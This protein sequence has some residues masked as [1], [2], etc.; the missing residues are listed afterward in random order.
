MVIKSSKS[1]N[2][3]IAITGATGSI[4]RQLV[5]TLLE[6]GYELVLLGRNKNR[7]KKLYDKQNGSFSLVQTDYGHD[8][9]YQLSE[10]NAIVHLAGLRYQQYS[11]LD[12]YLLNNF[13][14]TQRL[15]SAAL[16][17]EISNIVFAST[18]SVY[19]PVINNSPFSE[20]EQC[21]PV[22]PY[23]VSKLVCEKIAHYYNQKFNLRIKCLRI[24][25]VVTANERF[26]FML[27]KM[28]RSAANKQTIEIWGKGVGIRDYIYVKDVCSAILKSLEKSEAQGVF[29]ICCGIPVT[30]LQLAETINEVFDNSGNLVFNPEK[31]EDT[32]SYILSTKRTKTEL[33]WEAKWSLRDMLA[34][35]SSE[36]KT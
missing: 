21:F 26:E 31:S 17:N 10:A 33:G 7:L 6:K 15:F 34:D 13:S 24:S 14:V 11:T 16:F 9:N 28:L 5:Y 23:G 27:G 1:S 8:L 20:D 4:G 18:R 2:V 32:Q 29:N 35:M 30:N 3:K 19:N 25:Q 22:T 12:D 36:F